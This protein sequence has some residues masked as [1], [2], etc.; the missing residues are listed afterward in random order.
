MA[1]RWFSKQSSW[2]DRRDSRDFSICLWR[3]MGAGPLASAGE[4]DLPPDAG[5]RLLMSTPR[6]VRPRPRCG[7]LC[8]SKRNMREARP[9]HRQRLP[10]MCKHRPAGRPHLQLGVECMSPVAKTG[11]IK[12]DRRL[13][14]PRRGRS[15]SGGRKTCS[16]PVLHASPRT[17][18]SPGFGRELRRAEERT[19]ARGRQRGL[20]ENSYRRTQ[21]VGGSV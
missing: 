17:C 7:W 15:T 12:H 1:W 21:G 19:S 20:Y 9:G 18:T 6:G 8:P 16:F 10:A 13:K 4:T 2:H 3:L 14:N 11:L 5:K